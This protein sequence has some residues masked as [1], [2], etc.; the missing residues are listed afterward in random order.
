M[1]CSFPV[2][3]D[4]CLFAGCGAIQGGSGEGW[5]VRGQKRNIACNRGEKVQT[6]KRQEK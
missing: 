2:Q 4:C 6:G 1:Q 3:E 5:G